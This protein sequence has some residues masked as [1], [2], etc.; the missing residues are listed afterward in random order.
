[1]KGSGRVCIDEISR[2]FPGGTGENHEKT[3]LK[4][5]GIPAEI[6]TENFVNSSLELYCCVNLI[7]ANPTVSKT[8]YVC[9]IYM[10]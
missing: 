7:V 9:L 4:I 3:S 8:G 1:L 6:R 5:A 10:F 2:N